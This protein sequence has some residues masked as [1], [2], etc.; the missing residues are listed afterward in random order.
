MS[1]DV[2]DPTWET[3]VLEVPVG[4]TEL[5]VNIFLLFWSVLKTNAESVSPDSYYYQCFF[6]RLYEI[7]QPQTTSEQRDMDSPIR[8]EAD[9]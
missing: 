8:A 7:H 5:K 4:K 9:A 2:Y 1:A 3:L 6:K